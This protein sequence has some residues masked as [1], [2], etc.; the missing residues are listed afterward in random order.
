MC[1]T[2]STL[3]ISHSFCNM[4]MV[5]LVNIKL[6]GKQF[7]FISQR[8]RKNKQMLYYDCVHLYLIKMVAIY[9]QMK[10]DSASWQFVSMT[11]SITNH[12]CPYLGSPGPI[13]RHFIESRPN[14]TLRDC[15]FLQVRYMPRVFQPSPNL[16]S[17][18]CP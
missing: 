18:G 15:K 6:K 5:Q 1:S 8:R 17:L 11:L 3:P 16:F 12:L 2:A 13:W 14:S 7:V 4:E 10:C 9:M